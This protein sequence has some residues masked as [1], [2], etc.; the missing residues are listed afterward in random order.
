MLIDI[1]HCGRF[2]Q[3]KRY[4]SELL[5]NDEW[6]PGPNISHINDRNVQFACGV[7]LSGHNLTMVAFDD[8]HFYNWTSGQ[9]IAG[10]NTNMMWTGR[11]FGCAF[12]EDEMDAR[13]ILAGGSKGKD[14]SQ[15]LHVGEFLRTGCVD[16]LGEWVSGPDLPRVM[17]DSQIAKLDDGSML[18]VG[19][20][21][22]TKVSMKCAIS[23]YCE[24][25]RQFDKNSKVPI[26]V[27]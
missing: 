2:F 17:I 19:S 8:P 10:N 22:A 23:L 20:R 14:R 27:Y 11:G 13:I 26:F 6:V 24:N 3:E 25:H 1:R 18:M 9:W 15:V 5:V 21:V 7:H 12:Y 16:D 4:T